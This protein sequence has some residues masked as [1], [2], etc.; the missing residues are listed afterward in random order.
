MAPRPLSAEWRAA[1][2]FVQCVW[3]TKSR[4]AG[5]LAPVTTTTSGRSRCTRRA[6]IVQLPAGRSVKITRAPAD[7]TASRSVRTISSAPSPLLVSATSTPPRPVI[8]ST[9]ETIPMA[10]SPCPATRARGTSAVPAASDFPASLIVFSQIPLHK[11]ALAARPLHVVDQPLVELLGRIH[12]AV[13]EQMVHGNHL[14][15]DGDVLSRIER[16]RDLGHRN[17]QDGHGDAV[18]A[19]ALDDG[20]LVPFLEV[21]HHL[22]ALLLP[23]G[24]DAEYRANVDQS[25]AAHLHEVPLQLVA[26]ADQEVGPPA[27]HQD[28]IVGDQPVAA[29]HEIEYTLGFP[30]AALAGEQQP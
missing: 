20:I 27:R 8:C 2:S 6:A 5:R 16:D 30:D 25:D 12:P 7:V 22:D 29:L 17:A 18:E 3:K 21:D 1:S 19:C 23:H 26:A 9:A 10:N 11:C 24:T 14:R 4:S 28:Q 13:A 15:H